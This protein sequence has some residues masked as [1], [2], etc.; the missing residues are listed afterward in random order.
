MSQTM[1]R[2]HDLG[3]ERA[4]VRTRETRTVH[5]LLV[6]VPI[7][8]PA[9]KPIHGVR[10]GNPVVVVLTCKPAVLAVDEL[11]VTPVRNQTKAHPHRWACVW[12]QTFGTGA[13]R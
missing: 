9:L 11:H 4:T 2:T 10:R 5:K 1:S 6:L 3:R 7:N 12:P 8:L 13:M